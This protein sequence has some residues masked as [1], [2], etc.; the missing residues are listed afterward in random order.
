MIYASGCRVSCRLDR[1]WE[2]VRSS[3][4]RHDSFKGCVSQPRHPPPDT[5]PYS[6]RPSASNPRELLHPIISITFAKKC[7]HGRCEPA[8][9]IPAAQTHGL[10]CELALSCR[11][12]PTRRPI[13][14]LCAE[15]HAKRRIV[16]HFLEVCYRTYSGI[17]VTCSVAPLPVLPD[18]EPTD[19]PAPPLP[20]T[21]PSTFPILSFAPLE[22][23]SHTTLLS[24]T[25]QSLASELAQ[26]V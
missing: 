21:R 18:L 6:P 5:I 23:P 15:R 25:F 8:D 12:L 4:H 17:S 11:R 14:L 26:A 24:P 10:W 9:D 2:A 16:R 13:W 19:S 7:L 1:D 3:R 20:R 22:Y